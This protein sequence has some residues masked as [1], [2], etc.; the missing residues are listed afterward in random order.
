MFLKGSRYASVP[1][2]VLVDPRGRVLRYK[3][4]RFLRPSAAQVGHILS[5]GERVEHVAYFYYRDPERF[6]RICDANQAMDPEEL[7][8]APGRKIG[9][10]ASED[11]GG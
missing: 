2:N 1:E 3:T 4:T 6:W 10:P 8:H 9:I 7:N 11:K 5:D